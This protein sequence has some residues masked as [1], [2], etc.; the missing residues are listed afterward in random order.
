L[1][2]SEICVALSA[3]RPVAASSAEAGFVRRRRDRRT[4]A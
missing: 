3:F 2:L 1:R 4:V